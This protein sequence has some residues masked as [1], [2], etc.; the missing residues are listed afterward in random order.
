MA[1]DPF[2]SAL[3]PSP[4]P[5]F[6]FINNNINKVPAQEKTSKFGQELIEITPKLDMDNTTAASGS[7]L[8]LCYHSVL[9]SP[10]ATHTHSHASNAVPIPERTTFLGRNSPFPQWTIQH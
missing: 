1:D 3:P 2:S 10:T 6:P 9:L 4:P 5:T 8:S 7:L